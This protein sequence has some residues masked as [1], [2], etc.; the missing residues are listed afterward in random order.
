MICQRNAFRCAMTPSFSVETTLGGAGGF[1][2]PPCAGPDSPADY[3][4]GPPDPADGYFCCGSYHEAR[5]FCSRSA[6]ASGVSAPV[7][8]LAEAVQVSFSRFGVPRDRI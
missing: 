1:A 3:R 8:T 4:V 2:P 6:A 5:P 7:M